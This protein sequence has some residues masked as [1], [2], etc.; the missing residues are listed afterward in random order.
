MN[1]QFFEKDK[2]SGLATP[3]YRDKHG[4]QIEADKRQINYKKGALVLLTIALDNAQGMK[5]F[6][7]AGDVLYLDRRSTGEIKFRPDTAW[8]AAFPLAANSAIKGFPYSSLLLE[9]E[10]QAGKIAYVWAGYGI[11]IIPPNQDI[12]TIGSI[13][14]PV[15]LTEDARYNDDISRDEQHAFAAAYTHSTGGGNF[16]HVMLWNPNGSG[17]IVY[18]DGIHINALNAGQTFSIRLHNALGTFALRSA[19][20]N[21]DAYAT[22]G[23]A[24]VYSVDIGSVTGSNSLLRGVLPQS[25][26]SQRF[27]TPIRLDE[28]EGVLVV[29]ETV[30]SSL[31]VSFEWRERA[32]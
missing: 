6:Q 30:A 23:A 32:A 1:E 29:N 24:G 18:V 27:K 12:T 22:A 25:L 7:L 26:H 31:A 5:E 16:G 15:E 11:E 14:D 9:W 2:N 4:E 10:A 13:T 28:Q 20:V 17:K 3:Q 21:L 8:P 19:G